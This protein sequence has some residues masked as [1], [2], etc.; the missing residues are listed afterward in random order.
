MRIHLFTV[1]SG[2]G[3]LIDLATMAALVD[4]GTSPFWANMAG[5]SVAIVFVFFTAQKHLFINADGLI[6][7]KFVYYLIYQSAAVPLAS[8][9]IHLLAA[10]FTSVGFQDL[11]QLI[12]LLPNPEMRMVAV[13]IVA[14]G[15]VTPAT[16]YGNFIFMGVLLERRLSF[17]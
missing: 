12:A 5:A 16:L 3:W 11:P 4:H 17:W 6:G 2:I 10:A 9:V 13:P 15:L 7:R 14:K 1:I 8:L